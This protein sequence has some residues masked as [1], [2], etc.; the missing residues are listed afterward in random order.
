MIY[1]LYREQQL[2][3][4]IDTAW[5]FFTSPHNLPVIA[6][7]EMDFTVLT[8]IGVNNIHE[9]M[10]VD[11]R[12]KPLLG[13]PIRWKSE[14]RSVVH[15]KCFVDY[16][17]Q[18]PY[19]MWHHYHEFIEN[20]KGVLMKDILQYKMYFGFI[21]QIVNSLI[22]RK[23]LEYIFNNRAVIVEQLFNKNAQIPMDIVESNFKNLVFLEQ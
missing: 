20:D 4:S 7:K 23:K 9:G 12:L 14:I 5:N 17:L 2:Q 6:P 13:I 19:R 1:Q 16:Q 11:Y 15:K 22:I 8:K 18:G 10:Q 21:G 3:C